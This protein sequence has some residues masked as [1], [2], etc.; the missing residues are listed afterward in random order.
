[1]GQN[2]GTDLRSVEGK[3]GSIKLD[4]MSVKGLSREYKTRCHMGGMSGTT[5]HGLSM[6]Y[7]VLDVLISLFGWVSLGSF[8]G[9]KVG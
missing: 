4:V 8:E 2:S 1:M 6:G 7:R 9:I 5:V 3:N